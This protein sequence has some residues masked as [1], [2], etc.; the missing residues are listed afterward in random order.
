MLDR[1]GVD[2]VCAIGA[3]CYPF[4]RRDFLHYGR[5]RD[6]LITVDDPRHIANV[7]NRSGPLTP[8]DIHD[9]AS[10]IAA[11]FPPAV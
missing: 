5:A 2:Y 9:L 4:M 8:N 10:R 3:L 6:G 11:V 1:Q 7:A